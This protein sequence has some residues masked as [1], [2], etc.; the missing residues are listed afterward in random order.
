MEKRLNSEFDFVDNKKYSN[1]VFE[2]QA[3]GKKR[4]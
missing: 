3:R 1:N 4:K 2:P